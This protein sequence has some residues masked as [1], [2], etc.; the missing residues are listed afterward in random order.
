MPPRTPAA[1]PCL[2]IATLSLTS[3]CGSPPSASTAAAAPEEAAPAPQDED[4]VATLERE[5]FELTNRERRRYQGTGPLQPE[6]TLADI[7]RAHSEDMLRRGFFSHQ[8]PDGR[9]PFDRMA[10]GHRRLVG[11]AGE[12]IWLGSGYSRVGPRSLAEEVMRN[13]TDSPGHRENILRPEFTHLGVGVVWRGGEVRATQ[14]FA[15][16]VGYVA[17]PVPA[18]V[19]PGTVLDLHTD[20]AKGL[21]AARLVDLWDPRRET[22]ASE[23]EQANQ[24]RIE[25]RPG[26]YRLRFYL[27]TGASGYRIFDGPEITVD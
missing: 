13:W 24:M 12:N 18:H 2:L 14:L 17:Q 3:A 22:T 8:N 21:P 6:A 25:A 20:P 9:T 11:L 26:T 4:A 5:I 1:L 19:N 23:P 10:A 15:T 16:V 7:A 27:P